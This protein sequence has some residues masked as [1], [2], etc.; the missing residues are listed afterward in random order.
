MGNWNITIR[1]VGAHH[2]KKYPK[3]ANRMAADFVKKLKEAGHI[4]SHAS[5]THGG[6][7]DITDGEKYTKDRD[8]I[9]GK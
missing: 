3:D 5:I 8:D 2:N 1:G 6:E 7:D 4:V 9:E